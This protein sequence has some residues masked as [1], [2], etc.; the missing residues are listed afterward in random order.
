MILCTENPKES[1]NKQQNKAQVEL[2]NEV[3]KVEGCN[4]NIKYQLYFHILA[5]SNLKTKSRKQFHL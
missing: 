4:I 5:T 1:T 2:T 3:T